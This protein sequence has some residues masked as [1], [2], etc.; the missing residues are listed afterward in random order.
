MFRVG[1]GPVWIYLKAFVWVHFL[2]LDCSNSMEISYLFSLHYFMRMPE[3]RLTDGITWGIKS[4]HFLHNRKIISFSCKL[5]IVLRYKR[6]K[7]FRALSKLDIQSKA[8]TNEVVVNRFFYARHY[9]IVKVSMHWI[10]LDCSWRH[11]HWSGKRERKKRDRV[12]SNKEPEISKSNCAAKSV[13]NVLYPVSSL[14]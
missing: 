14:R 2:A 10:L 12:L 11:S 13:A 1:E 3:D 7:S 9:Y 5:S 4:V 8:V 6:C